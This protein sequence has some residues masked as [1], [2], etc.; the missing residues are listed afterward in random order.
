V[1]T[2]DSIENLY[3]ELHAGNTKDLSEGVKAKLIAGE[4]SATLGKTLATIRTDA[5]IK[6][7]IDTLHVSNLDTQ[8][9]ERV[10]LKLGF[11]TLLKR[12]KGEEVKREPK[13][14]QHKQDQQHK[15]GQSENEQLSLV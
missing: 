14:K 13:G 15:Q 8:E 7:M 10:F 4:E 2:Y 12:L 6:I 9:A 3:K 5:P 11:S 1:N